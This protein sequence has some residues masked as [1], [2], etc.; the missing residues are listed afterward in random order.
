MGERR[1]EISSP[2]TITGRATLGL[3]IPLLPRRSWEAEATSP[4]SSGDLNINCQQLPGFTSTIRVSHLTESWR[5]TKSLTLN[6]YEEFLVLVML[7]F[8][9]CCGVWQVTLSALRELLF[10]FL[11]MSLSFFSR[12]DLVQ[13]PLSALDFTVLFFIFFCSNSWRKRV[14]FN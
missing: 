13:L 7:L 8:L 9:I 4:L 10:T 3:M 1:I 14:E 11:A 12:T 2:C 6:I 5:I